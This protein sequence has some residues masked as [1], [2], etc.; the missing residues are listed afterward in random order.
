MRRTSFE[1]QV[2]GH[3]DTLFHFQEP[4]NPQSLVAKRVTST[5][6]IEAQFY[7]TSH[8]KTSR[9]TPF[10]PTLVGIQSNLDPVSNTHETWIVMENVIGGLGLPSIM[11]VKVGTRLYG[12]D[13]SDEKRERMIKAAK[14]T[15]SGETGLRICG[16]KFT[17][18]YDHESRRLTDVLGKGQIHNPITKDHEHYTRE[19]GRSLT[20]ETLHLGIAEFFKHV[21]K[22]EPRTALIGQFVSRLEELLEAVEQTECRLYGAS[23]LFGFDGDSVVV[24]VID[25]AHSFYCEGEG[26]DASAVVGVRNLLLILREIK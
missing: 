23:V 5:E 18:S 6:C 15:T 12:P 3:Q 25:F 26:V 22:G 4:G 21:E 8:A 14:A 16:M 17:S 24:K 1:H 9:L 2:A 10:L 7:T 19:Y 20:V 11:D 13:A